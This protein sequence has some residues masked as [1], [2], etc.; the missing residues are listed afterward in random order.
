MKY[1]SILFL[2]LWSFQVRPTDQRVTYVYLE[3][4]HTETHSQKITLTPVVEMIRSK[5]MLDKALNEKGQRYY[6]KNEKRLAPKIGAMATLLG[7]EIEA[8]GLARSD[9]LL[10]HLGWK[11]LTSLSLREQDPEIVEELKVLLVIMDSLVCFLK[12]NPEWAALPLPVTKEEAEYTYNYLP[13]LKH[14]VS[15]DEF[16]MLILFFIKNKDL[17]EE[18]Y[19][20]LVQELFLFIDSIIK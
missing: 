14:L 13:S 12:Q 4:V 7:E 6:K 20:G 19:L 15:F 9:V 17:D 3:E 8:E 18:K 16:T 1:I 2:I 10:T 11:P 5:G